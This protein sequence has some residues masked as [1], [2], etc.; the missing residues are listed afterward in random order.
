MRRSAASGGSSIETTS[1]ASTIAIDSLA[2]VPVSGE[3]GFE[4]GGG[5][6]E[7]GPDGRAADGFNRAADD[8]RGRLVAAHGVDGY[9]HGHLILAMAQCGSWDRPIATLLAQP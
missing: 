1:G 4:S 5:A 2:A 3:L 9:G 7:E 6:D 8:G